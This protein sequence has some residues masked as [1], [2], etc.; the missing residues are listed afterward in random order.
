MA[1][2]FRRSMKLAPGVRLNINK[3]GPGVRV[4]PKGARRD[5][6]QPSCPAPTTTAARSSSSGMGL[7]C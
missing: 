6:R 1:F 4:G 5:Q 7:G 2:R 3:G